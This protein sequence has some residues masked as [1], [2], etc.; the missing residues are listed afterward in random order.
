MAPWALHD[1]AAATIEGSADF[2]QQFKT[3]FTTE[4]KKI[5]SENLYK[6]IPSTAKEAAV[7][8]DEDAV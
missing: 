6:K 5:L 2:A 7:A 8:D 1:L 3:H 4:Y